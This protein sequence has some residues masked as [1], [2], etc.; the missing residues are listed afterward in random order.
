MLSIGNCPICSKQIYDFHKPPLFHKSQYGWTINFRSQPYKL[1]KD[2][3]YLWIL[4]TD[5]SR[6]N[7][8]ICKDCLDKI[9]DEQVK[10]IFADITFT[11]LKQ[12]EKDRRS[13]EIKYRLFE[14]IRDIQVYIWSKDEQTLID[15]LGSKNITAK[16][17]C[18]AKM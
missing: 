7:V 14:R 6:M 17:E 11:K 16:E 8:S 4:C 12:V 15:Y 18:P 13:D 2:G 5:S 9:T 3:T 10:K 1:N